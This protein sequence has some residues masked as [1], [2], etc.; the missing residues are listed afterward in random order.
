MENNFIAPESR[1][2]LV[3]A[4]SD[5]GLGL[6]PRLASAPISLGLHF[7]SSENL[8]PSYQEEH[9]PSKIQ[10]FQKNLDSAEASI[11]LVE[12]F[13]QWAGGIDILIQLSGTI[14][15]I[16][17]WQE[18]TPQEW[19]RDLTINCS[20][21]FFLARTAINQMTRGGKIVLMSTASATH[22]GGPTSFAYGVAKAGIEAITRGLAKF[23]APKNIL[24]NAIRPGF[25]KTR[26]HSEKAGKSSEDLQKR[27]KSIPL[28][29]EGKPKDV[30]EL[31]FFLISSANEFITGECIGVTGGD[32]L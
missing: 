6:I 10:L 23:A 17:S 26:F 3:G 2:L 20:S 25:I 12:E 11:Q 29:R 19:D 7:F 4:S 21:P 28:G 14:T 5:I 1:V 8:F 22:G 24:V 18:I 15:K 16:T 27:V 30:D 13:C 9:F 32:F 31:I